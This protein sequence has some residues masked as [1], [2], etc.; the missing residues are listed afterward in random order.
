M[1]ISIPSLRSV[2]KT[3]ASR[4]AKPQP[5]APAPE[6][7][8][9]S[10]FQRLLQAAEAGNALAQHQLVLRFQ[11]GAGVPL[12]WQEAV[13]W[14]RR[15]AEQG[16]PEQAVACFAAAARRHPPNRIPLSIQDRRQF[17]WFGWL[18]T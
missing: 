13:Y 4:F 17:S 12:D 2:L 15:A 5:A 16:D 14:S 1:L 8:P 18:R 7:R 9:L 11:I 6:E 3:L 10:E